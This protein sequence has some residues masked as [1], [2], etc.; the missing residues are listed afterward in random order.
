MSN[1]E[2]LQCFSNVRKKMVISAFAE[3]DYTDFYNHAR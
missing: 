3:I 2:F 1:L